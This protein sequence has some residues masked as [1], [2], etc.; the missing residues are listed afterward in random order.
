MLTVLCL[1]YVLKKKNLRD[2]YFCYFYPTPNLRGETARQSPF[3]QD[4]SQFELQLRRPLI[5]T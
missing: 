3:L 2:V 1:K 5:A 4:P